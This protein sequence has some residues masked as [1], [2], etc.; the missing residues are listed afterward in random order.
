VN[1]GNHWRKRGRPPSAEGPTTLLQRWLNENGFTAADL[2]K[3]AEMTR[4]SLA[5]PRRGKGVHLTT[6]LRILAGARKLAKRRVT[7]DELFPLDPDDKP[8]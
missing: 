6:M 3:A 2:E 7:M 1:A 4:E 5:R 8:P